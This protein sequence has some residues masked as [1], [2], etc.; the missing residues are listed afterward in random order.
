LE[1]F[2]DLFTNHAERK[3]TCFEITFLKKKSG[4]LDKWYTFTDSS[5]INSLTL[6][7]ILN[8]NNN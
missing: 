1:I 4:K 6:K 3:V 8:K 5:Q 7:S 2:I